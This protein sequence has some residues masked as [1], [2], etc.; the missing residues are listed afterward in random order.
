[1]A[2]QRQGMEIFRFSILPSKVNEDVVHG[3]YVPTVWAD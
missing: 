3:V 2:E 1:M